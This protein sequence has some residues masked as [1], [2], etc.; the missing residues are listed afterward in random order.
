MAKKDKKEKKAKGAK[1]D[2]KGLKRGP[3]TIIDSALAVGILGR[4]KRMM[5]LSEYVTFSVSD[6]GL[7]I[8]AE[9]ASGFVSLSDPKCIIEYSGKPFKARL[10]WA[11]LAPALSGKGKVKVRLEKKENKI[12]FIG[13]RYK[14]E[15]AYEKASDEQVLGM[16]SGIDSAPIREIL[17]SY[18]RNLSLTNVLEE[19]AL[20]ASIRW[21]KKGTIAALADHYH[22][23]ILEG[24]AVAKTEGEIV[25]PVDM[26]MRLGEIGG[27]YSVGDTSVQAESPEGRGTF[28]MVSRSQ[29][30]VPLASVLKL[31]DMKA[32][33]S[34]DV[35]AAELSE[36]LSSLGAVS[37]PGKAS[38]I[39]LAEGKMK[40]G[41][42]SRFGKVSSSLPF[43][44]ASGKPKGK[45]SFN[46][47]V[48]TEII[49]KFSGDRLLIEM[50]DEANLLRITS[51]VP[52]ESDKPAWTATG[53]VGL[54]S[55]DKE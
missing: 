17:T 31:K 22:A 52:K 29:L 32:K 47:F 16:S 11:V 20:D 36:A 42:S 54:T 48:F 51:I 7:E 39:V 28:K 2:K 12:H 35:S 10:T 14:A 9:Y 30:A 41:A 13:A 43:K 49:D 37:E 53:F 25:L 6:K 21:S 23:L 1:V 38:N 5:G 45:I 15:L 26:L 40:A 44:K 3:D 55:A 50:C 18:G 19:Q 33:W 24:P 46:P 27:Q 8:V 34:I 4:I